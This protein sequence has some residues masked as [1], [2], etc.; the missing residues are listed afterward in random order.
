M[1]SSQ[2]SLGPLTIHLY[3]LI[4]AF[5]IYLSWFLAKKR[6]HLHKIP[7]SLFEDPILLLPLILGITGARLYH[8]IDKWFFYSRDLWQIPSI[9]NGGLGIWGAIGGIVVGF[10]LIAK[11]R[12]LSLLSLLDLVS[13][14]LILGQ[15]IGRIGNYVNQEG[16]GPPTD[17]PWAVYI[18][19]QNRPPDFINASHFHP[20]FFY[21]ATLNVIFFVILIN[22]AKRFRK[23]GQIFAAYLI[24]Y[25][26]GRFIIE[27]WRIDT[28]IIGTV[29]VAHLI[30][31]AAFLT[32][33][34]ILNRTGRRSQSRA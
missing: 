15:A 24:L 10:A 34:V 16:F 23:P 25:S 8:V 14:S 9:W 7:K 31:I 22:F 28:W 20:T 21:E 26:L 27:F 30:S 5:A 29:K 33:L 1:I 4:I 2:I 13:P 12:R 32:A 3:G 18:S 17:S 6:A 19:P 11:K